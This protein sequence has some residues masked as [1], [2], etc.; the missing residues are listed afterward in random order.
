MYLVTCLLSV[1]SLLIHLDAKL[2]IV[3]KFTAG[4]NSVNNFH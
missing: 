2:E 4:S 3:D 1:Y